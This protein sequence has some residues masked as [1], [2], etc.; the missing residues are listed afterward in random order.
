MNN[1]DIGKFK[2]DY[3]YEKVEIDKL[4]INYLRTVRFKMKKN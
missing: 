3:G 2:I 1:S 4:K